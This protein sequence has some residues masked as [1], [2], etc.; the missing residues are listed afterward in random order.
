M[1]SQGSDES[2]GAA[3][4]GGLNRRQ[5]LKAGAGVAAAAALVGCQPAPAAPT[6]APT[7]PPAPTKPVATVAPAVAATPAATA[8]VTAPA[9][10][11]APTPV[12]LTG[13]AKSLTS[14]RV[15]DKP[16][17]GQ[18]FVPMGTN[19]ETRLEM[20]PKDQLT[21]PNGLF[22][23]RGHVASVVVDPKQWKLSIEGSGVDKPFTLTYDELLKL[24]SRTVTRY[25]ECAGNGRSFYQTLMNKPAQ[26]GQWKLGAY[27]V[28]TWTGVPFSELLNRAGVKRTATEVM[29]VGLDQPNVRRPMSLAKAM[30]EDTILAYL[31]NGETLPIDHGFPAKAIVPGWVGINNIKW[32]GTIKVTEEHNSVEWNTNAYIM[33]GPDYPPPK[34]RKGPPVNEQVMKSAVALP[35]PATLK[36]GMQTVRGYAWTPNG[37]IAKVE[38]SLDAGKTWQE[39][40]LIEPN[41]ERAGVRW[42]F[43]FDARPGDM[44]IMPRAYDSKGTQPDLAR[45]KW[46]EQGYTFAA[47]V[48]HPV[49]VTA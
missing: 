27:G 21:T 44:T 3:V 37:K 12:P 5:F 34:D 24:P 32:V 42:E 11:A 23:V 31:M 16:T 49:K 38:V 43:S 36:A 40:R 15:I 30:E 14:P 6:T 9:A 33:I 13:G 25:I 17:P 48:P 10:T 47:P 18:F 1:A 45:A 29:P 41:I 20:L 2:T 28:A 22:F 26:G 8:A 19:A 7:S 4:E 35:W 46:N 39:A